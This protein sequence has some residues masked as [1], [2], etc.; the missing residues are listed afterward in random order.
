[1]GAGTGKLT[2]RLVA[3]GHVV[4][5]V[6]PSEQMLAHLRAAVPGVPALVGSA[7]TL[8]LADH[9]VDAVT[10][11][12][13]WHWVDESRAVPEVARVLRAGGTLGL[14]WNVRA[15]TEPWQR[16]LGELIADKEGTQIAPSD[17]CPGLRESPLFGPVEQAE[18]A[19]AQPLDRS[20]LVDL[21]ASRSGVAVLS[22]ADRAP[23][24][25]AV[26]DLFDEHADATGTLTMTYRTLAF[27]ARVAA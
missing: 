20:A 3:A 27:R 26:R 2:E 10:V 18:F 12:Q 5:A 4:V 7:E 23:I 9:S 21:A 8:P 11:A 19:V 25:A 6:D 22:P 24:L 1:V 16:R 14:I 17:L 13:A 15:E